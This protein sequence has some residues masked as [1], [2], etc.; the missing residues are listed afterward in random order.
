MIPWPAHHEPP[1]SLGTDAHHGDGTEST[2]GGRRLALDV[3]SGPGIGNDLD[4]AT[5]DAA[6][7]AR[8]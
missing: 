8:P 7:D 5:P 4:L 6:A 3:A 2:D 1:P